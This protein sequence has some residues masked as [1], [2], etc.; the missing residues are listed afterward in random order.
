[1]TRQS[2]NPSKVDKAVKRKWKIHR[3]LIKC[4]KSQWNY[5]KPA[6]TRVQRP[7]PTIFFR[8]MTFTLRTW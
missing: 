2:A 1:M 8:L 7:M 3:L 6:L 5:K 4:R